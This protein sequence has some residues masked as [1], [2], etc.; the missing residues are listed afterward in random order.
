MANSRTVRIL[1]RMWELVSSV[2]N[3]NLVRVCVI[4]PMMS[5]SFT[6]TQAE[7]HFASIARSQFATVTL[8]SVSTWCSHSAFSSSSTNTTMTSELSPVLANWWKFKYE[9][10]LAKKT[11]LWYENYLKLSSMYVNISSKMHHRMWVWH[12]RC[13]KKDVLS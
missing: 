6:S 2:L 12:D 7:L 5:I 8:W 11:T 3:F 9:K 1:Y 10:S 13:I 4:T